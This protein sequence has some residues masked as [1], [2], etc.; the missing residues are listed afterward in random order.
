VTTYI[1]FVFRYLPEPNTAWLL[2]VYIVAPRPVLS[3]YGIIY[4]TWYII[5]LRKPTS[6][7]PVAFGIPGHVTTKH[8]PD[9]PC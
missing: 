2:G 6:Q 3:L 1:R 4:V 9:T 8:P 5:L 7:I